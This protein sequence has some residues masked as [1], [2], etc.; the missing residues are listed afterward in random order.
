M[1]SGIVGV[2]AGFCCLI[3]G[4]PLGIVAVTLGIIGLAQVRDQQ[5]Q[6]RPMAIAGICCG[7]AAIVLPIILFVLQLGFGF[8]FNRY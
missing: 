1:I 5:V 6:G 2:L 4:I 3:F 8:A 7:V